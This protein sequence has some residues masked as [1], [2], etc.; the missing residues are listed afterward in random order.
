LPGGAELAQLLFGGVGTG[1]GL[2]HLA[3]QVGQ[4]TIAIQLLHLLRGQVELMLEPLVEL[5]DLMA[6]VLGQ[7]EGRRRGGIR[8]RSGIVRY[9]RT[10][11]GIE[12][13]GEA[14][15]PFTRLLTHLIELQAAGLGGGLGSGQLRPGA[16]EL[17]F[18]FPQG[19][20]Q[21]VLHLLAGLQRPGH[22]AAAGPEAR[23][24]DQGWLNTGEG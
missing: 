15:Q 22:A 3:T 6:G 8:R 10:A 21:V 13:A 16:A 1:L 5:L 2:R 12:L 11:Q 14:G 4:G 19:V 17:P 18:P 24:V 7:A 20:L 23:R 9:Q